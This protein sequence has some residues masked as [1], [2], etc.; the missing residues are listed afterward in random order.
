MIKYLQL[1]VL[2]LLAAFVTG[3]Q[4]IAR[5]IDY[6]PA[7]GQHI[8]M[9]QT[10][11][12]QAAQK[13][14]ESESSLVSLGAF[15]GYIVLK[16]D[17]ACEN[18]PDNPYGI[19][20]TVFGNAFSGSSEPGVVWVMKDKN[21]NGQPDDTWYEIAG[22]HH[23]HSKTQKNY[24]ITYF[25]TDSRS[26]LWKDETGNT[27]FIKANSYNTQEY[28]PTEEFFTEYP[29]DSV[30][31]TGTKLEANV[32]FDN[33]FQLS[34]AALDF[35][36]ADN[37][38]KKQGVDPAVPDN[39]YTVVKEG[40]GG[41]PVDI[42]W[43]VDSQGEY[44]HLD[45]IHFLK[46]VTGYLADLGRLGEAS[47]D[48]SYVV[49]IL[50]DAMVSGNENLL[51]LYHLPSKIMLGDTVFPEANYFES[52]RLTET[53]ITFSSADTDIIKVET[54]GKIIAQKTGTAEVVVTAEQ[55]S[56][57]LVME[58]VEPDSIAIQTEFSTIYPGDSI[59]LD[60]RVFDNNGDL[61]DVETNYT[62]STIS[63]G[64]IIQSGD[65]FYFVA[66]NP[67]QVTIVSKVKGFDLQKSITFRVLSQSD[68]VHVYFTLKTE[69][70]NILPRQW[71]EAGLSD[72]NS[73]VGNRQQDY[74]ALNRLTL[75]HAIKAGLQHA[76]VNFAFRDDENSDG[77]LYLYSVENDGLFYYGWGG[78]TD[79]RAYARAWI[80]RLNAS[81]YLNDFDAVEISNGDTVSLY[82][83]SDINSEW[84]YTR[85]SADKDSAN[86]GDPVNIL[87]EQTSCQLEENNTVSEE[88][89]LPLKNMEI[90]AEESYFTD[91][92]GTVEVSLNE[93]PP[94]IFYSGNDAIFINQKILTNTSILGKPEI[95]VYPNPVNQNLHVAGQNIAGSKI[96]IINSTG[97]TI[98]QNN[99]K[100]DH[101][102]LNVSTLKNGLY[103]LK[104]ETEKRV[105]IFK[106]IKQ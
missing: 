9:E 77:Q 99:A 32:N 14:A 22:S 98:L 75:A 80:A 90:V 72:I 5:T 84:K 47:T 3:A 68:K 91:E 69:N 55:Q 87:A 81:H 79:P 12:P 70:E 63:A 35:G 8:N 64:I 48:I 29:R 66:E 6:R 16:F 25:E 24:R 50:P 59:L 36:Y 34:V 71:M 97:E 2:L 74:S 26:A 103:I 100:T 7:P 51:V 17:E 62:S 83:I 56:K 95:R 49:D 37:H 46:I 39:P 85:L 1:T 106:F 104:T 101:V 45:E 31:F 96:S 4:N 21:Q 41:D 82:H 78:R 40:A 67:G 13:V 33:S 73:D 92:N 23:F 30:V 60:T 105:E 61:L 27:G 76:K 58:V 42:S 52:G 20:F 102:S 18:D 44:V 38:P 54:Q 65:A 57:R 43:A 53:D 19:D 86:A 10:G 94:W 15:G 11:T 93:N 89:F 28:Y 88:P